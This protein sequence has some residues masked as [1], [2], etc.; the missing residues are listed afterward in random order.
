[1]ARPQHMQRHARRGYTLQLALAACVCWILASTGNQLGSKVINFFNPFG[2]EPEKKTE[3]PS[4]EGEKKPEPDN[5]VLGGMWAK[6]K[7]KEMEA[8]EWEEYDWKDDA[9]SRQMERLKERKR[10]KEGR[11]TPEE[12]QKRLAKIAMWNSA[13]RQGTGDSVGAV[14]ADGQE[15]D[16]AVELQKPL[17]I[18]FVERYDGS[19]RVWVNEVREGFSAFKDGQVGVGDY[20]AE[21]NGMRCDGLS[22]NEVINYIKD[23]QGEIKFKF[24]RIF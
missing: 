18:D 2:G 23:A 6:P 7:Q 24:R 20:L 22:F 16:I 5:S 10:R 21:V 8:Q 13:K 3:P 12:R 9:Y 17:G 14:K 19:G 11:L 1:M 15:V 4:G